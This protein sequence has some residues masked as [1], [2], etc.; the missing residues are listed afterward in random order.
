MRKCTSV[1]QG[2]GKAISCCLVFCTFWNLSHV[3]VLPLQKCN[4][5]K[6]P[7]CYFSLDPVSSDSGTVSV[8]LRLLEKD[9]SMCSRL[10]FIRNLESHFFSSGQWNL[11][12][13]WVLLCFILIH[14]TKWL[15]LGFEQ[16]F[17]WFDTSLVGIISTIWGSWKER[18]TGP[19]EG[20]SGLMKIH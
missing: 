8:I 15:W 6:Y 1:A 19:G 10:C 13:I 11:V 5:Q 18:R 3:N 9:F 4:L 7:L 20:I 12:N 17:R 16:L 14:C 2:Q